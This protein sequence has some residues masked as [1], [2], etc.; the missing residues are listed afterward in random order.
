MKPSS[1]ILRGRGPSAYPLSAIRYPLLR[2]GFSLPEVMFAIMIMGIGFIMVA[3]MFPVAIQQSKDN[4][5]DTT[6]AEIA[7]SA[8]NTLQ[9]SLNIATAAQVPSTANLIPLTLANA[10]LF[11]DPIYGFRGSA[12]Y[13]LRSS[14]RLDSAVSS[15]Y[16]GS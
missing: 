12:I 2:S 8:V 3:A 4:Q 7:K 1:F 5:D 10:N 14:L 15:R 9:N 11:L 13:T 6:A 16:H